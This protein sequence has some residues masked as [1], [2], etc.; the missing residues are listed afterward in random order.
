MYFIGSRTVFYILLAGL[1]S[2][3]GYAQ[4]PNPT[5][6][7]AADSSTA[8]PSASSSDNPVVLKVGSVQITK[9][10]FESSVRS[11]EKQG[12]SESEGE[13][14]NEAHSTKNRRAL[15]DDYASV[16]MLSQQALAEHLDSSPDIRRQLEVAR[17]QVLS[18]AEFE[19][20]MRQARPSAD[21]I[22]AYYAAHGSDYDEIQIRRLFIWQRD[23][24]HKKA[25]ILTAQDALARA[26]QIRQAVLAGADVKKL[27]QDLK[28]SG[29]GLLDVNP[30]PFP[31][32]ELPPQ[33]ESVAFKLKEGEW[34]RIESA[35]DTLIFVQLVKHRQRQLG[36][37]IS[38][39]R[40]RLQSQK[41]Q[42]QLE[43]L[44]KKAGIWMDD[45]YFEAAAP[46]SGA[47]T[48]NSHPPRKVEKSAEQSAATEKKESNNNEN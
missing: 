2:V 18:D 25:S 15:G 19:R 20:L 3:V 31:R 21:E 11:F 48:S 7:S 9:E 27:A 41:M 23:E 43:V 14:E 47:K 10:E 8:K 16:V 5:S 13:G 34:S 22:S 28:E 24:T 12:E 30:L 6:A 40:D 33:M 37:V 39:V 46:V 45:K 42:A 32:G 38:L 4:S 36:E 29:D 35:P 17:L 26:D 44:R 1:L